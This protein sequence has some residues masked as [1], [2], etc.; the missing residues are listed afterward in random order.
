MRA[1]SFKDPP[2][3]ER[4]TLQSLQDDKTHNVYFAPGLSPLLA[5]QR[6][7]T[8]RIHYSLA[9]TRTVFYA[10][11]APV[12]DKGLLNAEGK[13]VLDVADIVTSTGATELWGP[14]APNIAGIMPEVN[15]FVGVVGCYDKLSHTGLQKRIGGGF[16]LADMVV[17]T[18]LLLGHF[19]PGLQHM[20]SYLMYAQIGIKIGDG[21]VEYKFS[22]NEKPGQK[23]LKAVEISV[24][25]SDVVVLPLNSLGTLVTGGPRVATFTQNPPPAS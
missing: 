20:A 14:H 25:N 22:G 15:I 9:S 10:A 13:L 3:G 2:K 24:S 18:L 16:C 4:D 17:K 8:P 23:V 6:A 5:N 12:N 21:Y 11:H 7:P 1:L 19:V